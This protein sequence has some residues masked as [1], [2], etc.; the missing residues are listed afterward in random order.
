VRLRR[1]R[2]ALPLH[3]GV[4]VV[5]SARGRSL[6]PPPLLAGERTPPVV[7]NRPLWSA[8]ELRRTMDDRSAP[9]FVPAPWSAAVVGRRFPNSFGPCTAS[10]LETAQALVS[11]HGLLLLRVFPREPTGAHLAICDLFAGTCDMIP[12]LKCAPYHIKASTILTDAD[13]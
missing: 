12:S 3:G 1:H 8:A 9:T 13:Y 5:A 10:L 7:L 11:C 2:R 4:Q 6:F